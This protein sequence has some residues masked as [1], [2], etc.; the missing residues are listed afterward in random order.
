MNFSLKIFIPKNEEI[1]KN[2]ILVPGV[3]IQKRWQSLR[4]AFKKE[5]NAQ[6][7]NRSGKAGKKRKKYEFYSQLRFLL[8]T[9]SDRSIT[10]SDIVPPD[11][12]QATSVTATTNLHES[13]STVPLKNIPFPHAQPSVVRN[14]KKTVSNKSY[15]ERLLNILEE[16]GKETIDEDKS[17]LLSLVPSFKRMSNQQKLKTKMRFLQI[18]SDIESTSPGSPQSPNSYSEENYNEIY[19]PEAS[20]QM[21]T[22]PISIKE[23]ILD[24]G[25]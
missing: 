10:S 3:K 22:S 15:E 20:E 24:L 8:P 4:T 23:E 14:K 6:R 21:K 18:L 19:V 1:F 17:F 9:L 13:T 5:Y 16:K 7:D 2:L 25:L 11:E 12:A